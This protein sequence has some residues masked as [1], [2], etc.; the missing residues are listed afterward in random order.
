VTD[1]STIVNPDPGPPLNPA[2]VIIDWEGPVKRREK[3]HLGSVVV[4]IKPLQIFRFHR[5][6]IQ[7]KI[8][9]IGHRSAG[10]SGADM[11]D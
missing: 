7:V 4:G 6:L 11:Q 3:S 5:Q 10:F 1:N 2:E 9:L 8:T